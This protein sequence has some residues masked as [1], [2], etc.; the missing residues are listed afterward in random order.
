MLLRDLFFQAWGSLTS[1]KL[2]PLPEEILEQ[3]MTWPEIEA[4]FPVQ[5]APRALLLQSDRDNDYILMMV[6][7]N[8]PSV[9]YIYLRTK[10]KLLLKLR[11][12]NRNQKG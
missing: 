2:K 6:F 10:T 7:I 12:C 1:L 3:E 11:T 5:D 8:V 9:T 4:N